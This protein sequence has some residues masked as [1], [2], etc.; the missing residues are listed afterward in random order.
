MSNETVLRSTFTKESVQGKTKKIPVHKQ[1]DYDYF[2][3]KT[4]ELFI[5]TDKEKHI[6]TWSFGLPVCD[7]SQS[8]HDGSFI[9][10]NNLQQKQSLSQWQ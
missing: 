7:A 10:L 4:R 9:L 8:K 5:T 2:K 1:K 3:I 6:F